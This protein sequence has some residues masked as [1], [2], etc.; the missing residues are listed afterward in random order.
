MLLMKLLNCWLCCNHSSLALRKGKKRILAPCC[1]QTEMKTT[2]AALIL[3][4]SEGVFV[5]WQEEVQLQLCLGCHHLFSAI[6][7]EQ[8]GSEHGLNFEDELRVSPTCRGGTST[9]RSQLHYF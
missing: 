2:G 9:S 4:S 5:G 7:C 6:T 1:W 3:G 8:V